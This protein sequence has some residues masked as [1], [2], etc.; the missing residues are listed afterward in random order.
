MPIDLSDQ[1][2][3]G[4][5]DDAERET[6]QQQPRKLVNATVELL[7]HVRTVELNGPCCPW[8]GERMAP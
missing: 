6:V 2:G 4:L 3:A 1:L 5:E 8:Q 7:G